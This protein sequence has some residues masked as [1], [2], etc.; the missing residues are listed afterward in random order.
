MTLQSFYEEV[1]KINGLRVTP[2]RQHIRVH[3][4]PKATGHEC[5]TSK[6]LELNAIAIKHGVYGIDE[7]DHTDYKDIQTKNRHSISKES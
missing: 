4:D 7:G 1:V 3:I 2:Y 5:A 6:S